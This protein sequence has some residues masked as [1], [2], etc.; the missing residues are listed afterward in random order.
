MLGYGETLTEQIEVKEG[1]G[2]KKP[3]YEFAEAKQ[4]VSAM[5]AN[6]ANSLDRLP[7]SVCPSG[8]SVASI[9]LHPEYLAKSYSP[10]GALE[11]LGLRTIGSRSVS[12]SPEKQT[13]KSARDSDVSTELFVAG[14]RSAFRSLSLSIPNWSRIHPA[15]RH[16]TKL[17]TIA[18]VDAESRLRQLPSEPDRLLLEVVLHASEHERDRFILAGLKFYLQ[19]LG[20]EWDFENVFFAGNLCFL[21]IHANPSEAQEVARFSFLRVLREMP[22]LRVGQKTLSVVYEPKR[23][24]LPIKPAVDPGIRV[25]ILDGG[26]PSD[27]PLNRWANVRDV[28]GVGEPGIE[29][30]AHGERVTSALLFGSI[31]SAT[32]DSPLC[33]V[34]HFRVLDKESENDPYELY[35]VLK[36]VESVLGQG[37]HEYV[38][39]S[40]GPELPIDDNE[41]HAWTAVLD[42][43][44]SDGRSFMA[45]AA[46]NTGD[47]PSFNALKPWRVQVP[48]DCV[49]GIT[50]GASNKSTRDGWER[51]AYSSIGPGRS[52][53]IVK[54]DLIAFGGSDME[55]FWAVDSLNPGK[56]SALQGTSFASPLTMRSAIAVRTH[57]GAVLSPLAIKALLIHCTQPGTF[58]RSEIGWGKL[59]DTLD[60]MVICPD[61]GVRIVYQDVISAA[62]YKRVHI[63]LPEI[64]APGFAEITA[65]F[66]FATQIDPEHPGSYTK[67]G[68]SVVFR[69]HRYKF[70]RDDSLHPK[71]ESFFRPG[72]LYANEH[73]LRRDAHKWET[74][75][76]RRKRK[77]LSSLKEPVFDIHYVARSKGGSTSSARKIRYA[78]VLTINVPRA[79]DL[80]NEVVR[81]YEARLAPLI[82]VIELPIQLDMD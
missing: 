35:E 53:G 55:P 65:T 36:R 56:A 40:I 70:A 64:D 76:H 79:D 13:R 15:A 20:L 68:L 51:A 33:R 25:A 12:V 22:R 19:E 62:K 4:R 82:P 58:E 52:P 16:L 59:P 24:E 14:K 7:A 2:P 73:Q 50:V 30:L 26:M 34:D 10:A 47:E 29:Y 74:T 27:S 57:F 38:N 41:V 60:E 6:T 75:L 9:V 8:E 45:I 18:A 32:P 69:P 43:H 54:P 5:L 11:R 37:G 72:G 49:N 61:N 17:E 23:I 71:S 67:S 39:L 77:R 21:R 31:A 42:E 63:P 48:S 80:Y 46:G 44:L 28:P 78:L 81:Q 1:G 66:C 3:P